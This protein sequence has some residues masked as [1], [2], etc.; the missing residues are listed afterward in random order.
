LTRCSLF[1]VRAIE[2]RFLY[3]FS[4]FTLR[5]P[6]SG[7]T[8]WF[9]LAN[10]Q[11]LRCASIP[12]VSLSVTRLLHCHVRSRGREVVQPLGG[13]RP[14]SSSVYFSPHLSQRGLDVTHRRPSVTGYSHGAETAAGAAEA[15]AGRAQSA[16]YFCYVDPCRDCR[17]SWKDVSK[18]PTFVLSIPSLLS[19]P[20]WVACHSTRWPPE[21][22]ST[23]HY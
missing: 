2:T 6:G 8:Y 13:R 21:R 11:P 23:Q 9:R 12:P 14:A 18:L 3:A 16:A 1:V 19:T 20:Q 10:D 5:Y 17:R 22:V 7:V 4:P 15:G